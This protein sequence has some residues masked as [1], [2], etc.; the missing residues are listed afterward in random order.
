[1]LSHAGHF[2]FTLFSLSVRA[3][4]YDLEK[5]TKSSDGDINALMPNTKQ[6]ELVLENH[7]AATPYSLSWMDFA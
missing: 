7:C 4:I 6:N 5:K 1:M 3:V 2:Y